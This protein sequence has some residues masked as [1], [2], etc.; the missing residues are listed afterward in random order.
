[1][2]FQYLVIRLL[3]AILEQTADGRIDKEL[4]R[5]AYDFLPDD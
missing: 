1:M 2:K 5:D 3:I 4:L